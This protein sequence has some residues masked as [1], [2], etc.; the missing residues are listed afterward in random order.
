MAEFTANDKW[1]N[2]EL[3]KTFNLKLALT[4]A[5]PTRG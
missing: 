4:F 2:S 5:P 3:A 1:V